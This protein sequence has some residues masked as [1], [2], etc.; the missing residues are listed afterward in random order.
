LNTNLRGRSSL[1]GR[2]ACVVGSGPNGLS[3]A[4]V[5][6]Q[7]GM[8][9]EVF[10]AEAQAGG[11]ARTMELTLPGF[12]H[13]F[14]SAV[15]P[16]AVSSPFFSS[17]PL[18]KF[19]LQWVHP[20]APVAHPLDDG[21]AVVHERDLAAI[22]DQLGADAGPWRR[23]MEPFA[24]HWEKLAREVLAPLSTFSRTPWLMIRL[25]VITLSSANAI[26]NSYFRG[27]R[28]KALFAGHAAHSFLGFDEALSATFGV[29]LGVT[30][31]AV[32]WPFP[33]GGAQ[34]ITDALTGCLHSLGGMVRTASPIR[35]MADLP[36]FDLTMW[37][38]SPWQLLSVADRY[39][40]REYRQDLGRYRYGSGVFKVDYALSQPI[41]WTARECLRAGTVHIGGTLEEIAASEYAA[42]HGK[43]PERPFVLLSQPTLFDSTRAPEG[44]HIA[45]AYCH[46]PNGSDFDMLPRL[47]AQIERF[48]PGFRDCVLARAVSNPAALEQRNANLVGG[49]IAGGASNLKQFIFRP[50]WRLYATS[51]PDMYLCSAS[52][53]PG[54]G[55]HGMCGY[56]AARLALSRLR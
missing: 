14:G 32:G 8:Q 7:A 2:R 17:L 13:D 25:G 30:A 35:T 3:A 41:P 5:L 44:K 1:S 26:A 43:H 55:V 10:E 31:H 46:V 11:S 34:A 45:W 38:V 36:K 23:L 19:G 39:L 9:V 27:A 22:D 6:A 28:A 18:D 20:D 40:S 29:L 24:I 15:H 37:D 42:R 47:E 53:P 56:N 12:R 21:T 33:R 49:D 54:A 51:A 50:T 48:A 4:I 16:M 52:T